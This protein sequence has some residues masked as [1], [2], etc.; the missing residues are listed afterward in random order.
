MNIELL[1]KWVER[2]SKNPPRVAFPEANEEKILLAALQAYEQGAIFPVLIG[3]PDQIKKAAAEYGI[4]LD[5]FELID[6]T[7]EEIRA[8]K[9]EAYIKTQPLLP[10]KSISRRGR[11]PMNYAFVLQEL[12]E[13]DC[14][15]VGLTYTTE[16]VILAAS[17]LIGLAEGISTVSSMGI[18]DLPHYQGSEGNM[19]A[20]ADA[21]VCAEPTPEELADI[22]IATCDTA[23]ILMEWEPRCAL[24]SFSTDGSAQHEAAQRVAEAVAIA[25]KKRPDLAIDGEFQLD[26]AIVP[27]VA[28]QKVK[29]DSK[30][31][32]KAN[33]LIY[34][35]L[36]AGNIGVKLVQQFAGCD[37]Y[38]PTLQGFAKPVSDC[39]RSAP[40]SELMGNIVMLAVR[41]QV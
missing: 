23:A 7:S 2:A 13:V 32:G 11:D 5:G 1:N 4:P 25:N 22:A 39:S 12:G 24:L 38:G 9:A 14:V 35:N 20:F 36:S 21:A 15:F 41:S 37:A 3:D 18:M 16:E 17:S 26:A 29:R 30:V 40:V 27:R 34:P 10:A 28:Q 19:L 33:I 6:N 8:A 31:A